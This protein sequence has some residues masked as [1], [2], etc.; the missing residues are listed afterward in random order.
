MRIL[1]NDVAIIVGNYWN[2]KYIVSGEIGL[3][4]YNK[5]LLTDIH[6]SF[7]FNRNKILKQILPGGYLIK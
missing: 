5:K 3:I 1:K 7:S 6:S 4:L 2:S